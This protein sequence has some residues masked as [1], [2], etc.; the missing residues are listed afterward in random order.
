MLAIEAGAIL[1][2]AVLAVGAWNR[3]PAFRYTVLGDDTSMRE[4]L[5][6]LRR[7]DSIDEVRERMGERHLDDE[8][9]YS[10]RCG[11]QQLVTRY[12]DIFL[13]GYDESDEI[14]VYSTRA[15]RYGLQFRNSRLV[16]TCSQWGPPMQPA[17]GDQAT[18]SPSPLGSE[19]R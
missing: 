2:A 7:G 12:P 11:L 8:S 16:G 10:M 18:T 9:E 6:T 14:L 17:T 15:R 5:K 4:V 1:L 13:Q 3:S 19:L